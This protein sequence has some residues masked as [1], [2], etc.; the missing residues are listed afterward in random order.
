MQ[1]LTC[2]QNSKHKAIAFIWYMTA[3]DFRK[4]ESKT[5]VSIGDAPAS[6]GVNAL[7]A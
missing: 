4:I 7:P 5:V 1:I 6:G 3:I 2:A